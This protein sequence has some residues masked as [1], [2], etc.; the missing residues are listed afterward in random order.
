M[1]QLITLFAKILNDQ[2]LIKSKN[3]IL[4]TEFYDGIL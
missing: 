2:S 4:K 1:N 3:K